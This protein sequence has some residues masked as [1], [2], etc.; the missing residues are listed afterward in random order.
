MS[1]NAEL[2][3]LREAAVP[4]GVGSAVPVFVASAEN[5]EVIDVE[6]RR[7]ID[8]ASGISVLNTGHRHPRVRAA[9]EAQVKH[10][11]HAAFQVTPYESYVR[12]AAALNDLVPGASPKQTA[13]FTTG[14][15]AVENAVKI[16]R[17]HS[18][19]PAVI[20]FSGGFHGRTL[21]GL[22]LTGRVTPYKVGFGP[23]PAD[24]FHAPFPVAYHGVSVDDAL[25]ALRSLLTT[26]VDP[27]RVAAM[28]VEPV[29]GE[30]GF[31]VAPPPFLRA[32]RS[33]CDDHGIL[34]IVD[35]IQT[36]FGRTGRMFAVEHADVTPDLVTMA[37]SLG[38]GLPLS[39]VTGRAD[40]M[41]A[42]APGGLG[43]TYGGSPLACA[44]A[45]AVLEVIRDEGLVERA[46]AIGDLIVDRLW[47]MKKQHGLGFIGDIR[48]LGAMVAMELVEDGDANRPDA[49]LA[50]AVVA[51][52][53]ESGLILI[54]CG[55]R[56]N[57][58]RFLTP[59]TASDEV[60][61]E[62]LDVLE[63]VL[64]AL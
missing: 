22:A 10:L 40:V 58:I 9:V 41:S 23:F 60:L 8:F 21:L 19:R 1:T 44:A 24:V 63:G 52:A 49:R 56:A 2:H 53:A 59:L 42:P 30:G 45:L 36:G 61:H 26:V 13:L 14:A 33:I 4:R 16:A 62:G 51:G 38:S 7:F 5:A 25:A 27:N 28:I 54:S 18:G 3:I 20:A 6:G 64:K 37:K 50:K 11:W 35:E 55:V 48:A 34:L 46:T 57:V 47:T 12:L 15:E 17:A 43:G 31:Y 29:Q 32:L 39:A